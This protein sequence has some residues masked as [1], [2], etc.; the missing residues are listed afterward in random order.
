MHTTNSSTKSVIQPSQSSTMGAFCI[1]PKGVHFATQASTEHILLILRRHPITQ[2]L[3]ILFAAVLIIIPLLVTPLL[4]QVFVELQIPSSY[5][6]V[7]TLFWYLAT[8]AFILTN[9]VLWYFNV[10]IV[11]NTRVLDIDFPSLLVQEV[12]GTHVEQI[13]DVTYQTIGVLSAIFNY[14][15]VYVQTA[16]PQENIEFLQVPQPKEAVNII[17]DLMGS[18]LNGPN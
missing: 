14:G 1:N 16:G 8:F 11:T 17:L 10:N 9:F 6:L 3:W 4:S 13:E 15:N 5:Q 7:V 12:T 18:K 2:L